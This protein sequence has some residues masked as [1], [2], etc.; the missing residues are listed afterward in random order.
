MNL[1][2]KPSQLPAGT[3]IDDKVLGFWTKDSAHAWFLDN[4]H[5]GECTELVFDGEPTDAE[6][7]LI[8]GVGYFHDTPA[9]EF[10]TDFR[11]ICLPL[12]VTEFIMNEFEMMVGSEVVFDEALAH[13]LKKDIEDGQ[14]N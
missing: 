3:R 5:C 7:G 8:A 2:L 10:F 6:K 14:E 4:T 11:I 9:D 1:D 12:E 13:V